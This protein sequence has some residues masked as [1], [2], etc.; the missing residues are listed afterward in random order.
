MTSLLPKFDIKVRRLDSLEQ[1]RGEGGTKAPYHWNERDGAF[2]KV[3]FNQTDQGGDGGGQGRSHPT[4]LA[5]RQVV[6]ICF[7]EERKT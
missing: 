3:P 2:V 7:P 6:M 4:V 1:E 5:L